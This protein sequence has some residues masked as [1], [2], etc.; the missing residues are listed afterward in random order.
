M[1]S[2]IMLNDIV[3]HEFDVHAT[4]LREAAR[5]RRDLLTN[6]TGRDEMPQTLAQKLRLET[7]RIRSVFQFEAKPWQEIQTYE[8]YEHCCL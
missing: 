2:T 3:L 5:A 6:E 7:A 4:R 8:H 1:T